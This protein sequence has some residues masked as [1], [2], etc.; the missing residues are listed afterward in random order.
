MA[1]KKVTVAMTDEMYDELDNERKKRRLAT[2]A[3]TA[4]VV[5]GDYLARGY[6]VES[7]NPR[8]KQD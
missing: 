1:M 2:G 6:W 3:E 5:I 8:P 7:Y 4:R